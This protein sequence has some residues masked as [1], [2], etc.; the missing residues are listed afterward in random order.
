MQFNEFKLI[1]QNALNQEI[2]SI[3]NNEIEF[4]LNFHELHPLTATSKGFVYRILTDSRIDMPDDTPIHIFVGNR[5]LN[6]QI[7]STDL[8]GV[9][10]SLEEKLI[11]EDSVITIKTSI[12]NLYELLLD[13]FNQI[14]LKELSF[15]EENSMKLFSLIESE[16]IASSTLIDKPYEYNKYY[17]NKDKSIAHSQHKAVTYSLEK[18]I[19]FMCGHLETDNTRILN[20]IIDYLV[21]SKKKILLVSITNSV[22]DMMLLNYYNYIK[23]N[24][25]NNCNIIK[26]G[27]PVEIPQINDFIFENIVQKEKEKKHDQIEYLKNRINSLKIDLNQYQKISNKLDELNFLEHKE[28]QAKIEISKLEKSIQDLDSEMN[29]IFNSIFKKEKD[30]KKIKCKNFVKR[31]FLIN[32]SKR[33]KDSITRDNS[34]LS[35]KHEIKNIYKD[36]LEQYKQNRDFNFTKK[37]NIKKELSEF[38][39]LF[40]IPNIEIPSLDIVIEAKRN[41]YSQIL[42]YT[43][44]IDTISSK[45]SGIEENII[46]NASVIGCTL[47]NTYLD[48]K[49]FNH[50]FDVMI[51]CEANMANLPSVLF[52]SGLINKTHYIMAGD[53]KHLQ[54]LVNSKEYSAKR[55]LYSNIFSYAG[56]KE[57]MYSG[58]GDDCLVVLNGQYLGQNIEQLEKSDANHFDKKTD[59]EVHKESLYSLEVPSIFLKKEHNLLVAQ[60]NIFVC[61]VYQPYRNGTNP[62]FDSFSKSILNLKNIKNLN[63]KSQEEVLKYFYSLIINKLNVF[64][65]FVFCIVP[66]HKEKETDTGISRLAQFIINKEYFDTKGN[67]CK[68]QIID[69][70]DIIKRVK[71]VPKK[72]AGGIKEES[73][74]MS[75]LVITNRFKVKGQQILLLDDVTT[76]GFSLNICRKLL[77]KNG[78]KIV[79]PFALGETSKYEMF[80]NQI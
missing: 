78:A 19:T 25:D 79:V 77:D 44:Q 65:K 57:K 49:I 3:K 67:I 4:S 62:D 37:N 40:D 34:N 71:T 24:G 16:N 52:A 2:E 5:C 41:T 59:F 42:K 66:S 70:T 76:K 36:N 18:E 30:L 53:C 45:I 61:G 6:G 55:W 75:S 17:T 58:K 11:S 80:G 38:A 48:S 13:R 28:S 7:V 56:I 50:N 64:E 12:S 22:V 32:K 39:D 9:N 27:N 15:N 20:I 14:S 69:G 46:N 68:S 47:N 26:C 35:R 33:I 43:E 1:F 31:I 10:I 8:E 29:T 73:L 51:L 74:E 23:Y 63:I 72:S 54:P 21:K 60:H